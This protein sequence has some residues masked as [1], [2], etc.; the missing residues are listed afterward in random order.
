M[1]L[2]TSCLNLSSNHGFIVGFFVVSFIIFVKLF[3]F[4]Y[5][6]LRTVSLSD[7]CLRSDVISGCALINSS[8]K[9]SLLIFLLVGLVSF[10]FRS[11][12]FSGLFFLELV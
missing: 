8:S 7:A 12:F 2:S 1:G 11:A 5:L 9:A 10:W 6:S 3:M 4:T